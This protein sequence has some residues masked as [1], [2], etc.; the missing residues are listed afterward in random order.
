MTPSCF[1]ISTHQSITLSYFL[2]KYRLY[3][4]FHTLNRAKRRNTVSP[5]IHTCR[6]FLRT[7]ALGVCLKFYFPAWKL[8]AFAKVPARWRQSHGELLHRRH[9]GRGKK[10]F[11]ALK[12]IPSL[13]HMA[14]CPFTSP[15][16]IWYFV[17]W[18]DMVRTFQQRGNV[19]HVCPLRSFWALLKRPRCS[20]LCD[21]LPGT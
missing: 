4:R 1:D 14:G 5:D 6:P 20:Q 19:S 18:A 11:I 3:L 15:V 7:C 10:C 9:R 12:R 2:F 16:T 17:I 21:M 13:V 8:D